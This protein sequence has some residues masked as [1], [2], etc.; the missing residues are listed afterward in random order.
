VRPGMYMMREPIDN[1]ESQNG[2]IQG[3]LLTGRASTI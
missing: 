3:E 2:R 1:E